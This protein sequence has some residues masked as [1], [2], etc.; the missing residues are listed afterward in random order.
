MKYAVEL[1]KSAEKEL[2]RLQSREQV[3]ISK[4]LLDLQE[5]PRPH[6]HKKLKGKDGLFRIRIGDY[7]AI[8]TIKDN[9]LLVLVFDI[10]HQKDIYE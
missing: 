7:R 8:Y 4:A 5:N 1:T 10:G 3:K 9:I 6:G 2:L